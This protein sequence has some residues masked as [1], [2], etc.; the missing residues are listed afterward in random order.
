MIVGFT[1]D[2][3]LLFCLIL[4]GFVSFFVAIKTTKEKYKRLK[5]FADKMVT[6]AKKGNLTARRQAHAFLTD[7]AVVHKLF[8]EFP[9][10]YKNRA[11]G[12]TTHLNMAPRKGDGAKMVLMMYM[13]TVEQIQWAAQTDKGV[14]VEQ[15]EMLKNKYGIEMPKMDEKGDLVPKAE[16]DDAT[17]KTIDYDNVVSNK[18]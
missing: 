14:P 9:E 5:P 11:R 3:M 16:S 13:D 2:F 15:V 1:C 12:Y 17:S 8:T 7:D 10:R 18:T 6:L 4:C